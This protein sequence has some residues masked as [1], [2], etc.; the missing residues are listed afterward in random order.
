[1]LHGHIHREDETL[2]RSTRYAETTVVNT[3]GHYTLELEAEYAEVARRVSGD[4]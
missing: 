3:C 1:M 4:L 2:P